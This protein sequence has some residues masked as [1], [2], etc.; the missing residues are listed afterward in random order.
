MSIKKSLL[1]LTFLVNLSAHA[2]D[3]VDT[4]LHLSCSN[5]EFSAEGNKATNGSTEEIDIEIKRINWNEKEPSKPPAWGS[6]SNI[7]VRSGD[8]T[9]EG[10]LLRSTRDEVAFSFTN[11]VIEN[12]NGRTLAFVYEI[13]LPKTE[14]KR[15]MLTLFGAKSSS[16]LTAVS[17]CKKS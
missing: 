9:Y 12:G 3:V 16:F 6:M 8:K 1:V 4:K 2:K 5:S 15:T 10:A 11:D 7:K 14:L 13:T 17:K